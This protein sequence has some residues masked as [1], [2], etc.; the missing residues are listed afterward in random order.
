MSDNCKI[1]H[2][3]VLPPYVMTELLPRS[4]YSF[5]LSILKGNQR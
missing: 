2:T 1:F 5:H 4:L 3:I